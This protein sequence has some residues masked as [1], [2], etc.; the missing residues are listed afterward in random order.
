MFWFASKLDSH[1]DRF[2]VEAGFTLNLGFWSWFCLSRLF[3]W[4]LFGSF[5]G[6]LRYRGRDDLFVS[7]FITKL[8]ARVSTVFTGLMIKTYLA[9]H[10][11]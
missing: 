11:Q 1:T 9:S 3:G 4:R 2:V 8:C 10:A 6:G 7:F 5:G